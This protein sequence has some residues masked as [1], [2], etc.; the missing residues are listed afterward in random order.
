MSKET[1]LIAE[2]EQTVAGLEQTIEGLLVNQGQF[3][4]PVPNITAQAAT[5]AKALSLKTKA[6]D[7]VKASKV[8]RNEARNLL[9]KEPV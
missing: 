6:I 9:G 5:K 1:E 8:K 2:L 3:L 4:A 7:N